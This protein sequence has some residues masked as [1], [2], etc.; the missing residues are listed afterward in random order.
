[1]RA[2]FRVG[3]LQQVAQH[4][5]G[6]AFDRIALNIADQAVQ[7]HRQ[8]GQQAAGKGGVVG[9][10]AVDGAGFHLQEQ[11]VF[12]KLR[13]HRAGRAQKHHRL[14]KALAGLDDL[15]DFLYPLRRADG[16]F[17]PPV[18]HQIQ[19]FAQIAAMKHHLAFLPAHLAHA[20]RQRVDLR[21]AELVKH[22]LM[23][24]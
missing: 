23:A 13:R 17:H 21:V 24:Q 3:V 12:Q 18:H 2:L 6:G 1:M 11:A 8:P 5:L 7:A 15:D 19:P 20:G 4:A 22:R 14:G 9:H 16:Q 10:G